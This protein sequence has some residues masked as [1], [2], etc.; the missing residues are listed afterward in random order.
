MRQVIKNIRFEVA[1]RGAVMVWCFLFGFAAIGCGGSSGAKVAAKD[2]APPDIAGGGRDAA[3]GE[4]GRETA[5]VIDG[6]YDAGV[7]VD[8]ARIDAFIIVDS[9]TA[10]V[11]VDA[12]V[13]DI[14]K[15]AADT[16]FDADNKDGAIMSDVGSD[17][18][19][20]NVL[21]KN[22][23]PVAIAIDANDAAGSETGIE[24]AAAVDAGYDS[25]GAIDS[26]KI[27]APVVADS[28]TPDIAADKGPAI[29]G[30]GP[31]SIK[32][33]SV[34]PYGQAGYAYGSVSGVVPAD[35]AVVV[36]I[37]VNNAWWIK[38]YG[39]MPLTTIGAGGA[40]S[41]NIVTGGIDQDATTIVAYLVPAGYAVPIL[42]GDSALPTS[43]AGFPSASVSR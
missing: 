15:A 9:Q 32:I 41:A 33:T 26:A 40:W 23:A 2:G 27:E 24:A 43:L 28:G 36:Y 13:P 14:A 8:A 3:P 38:P 19:D 35:H 42:Y 30:S 4:T 1:G 22:D 16:A 34:P 12:S 31:P 11:A 6:G 7:A 17:L 18:A 20:A 21:V 5:G 39:W 29:V 10:D 25:G 37:L